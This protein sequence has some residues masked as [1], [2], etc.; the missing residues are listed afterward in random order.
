MG[1]VERL[2]K[3]IAASGLCSRRKA[4]ELIAEGRVQ[5]NGEFVVIPGTKVDEGDEV[6][7]DG[8]AIKS[9]KLAYV[10]MNKPKGVVTTLSDPQKRP[11]VSRYLPD[12]GAALK[13]VG[14][15]DMDTDG[16]LLFTNDGELAAR[17]THPRYAVEKEYVAVVTGVVTE[18][19]LKQL[20]DGVYIEDGKTAPAMVRA[21]NYDPRR[22]TT[23]LEIVIHEGRNRQIRQMCDVV[24]NPVLELRRVRIGS[25]RLRDMRPGMCRIL[26]KKEVDTLRALVGLEQ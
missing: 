13:P 8:E 16:L 23:R 14:R 22:N 19:A 18:K 21:S 11:T 25:I 1:V 3:V 9:Q 6:R 10:L 4:E 17:L 26:G 5:V 12:I 20:R 24:G 2:H 7:V 15:L